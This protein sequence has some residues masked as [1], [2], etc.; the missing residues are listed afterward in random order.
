MDQ[1]VTPAAE[2]ART[3]PR[4]KAGSRESDHAAADRDHDTS[5]RTDA[6]RTPCQI[7]R[8]PG[9]TPARL[10]CKVL[11]TSRPHS[12]D[13][14]IEVRN[15]HK[16]HSGAD[17]PANAGSTTARARGHDRLQP[18][19]R[20]RKRPPPHPTLREPRNHPRRRRAS[21][22]PGPNPVGTGLHF[23]D[24]FIAF[25]VDPEAYR[26]N[27]TYIV[28][29]QGKPPDFVLE[30]ASRSTGGQDTTNKDNQSAKP[31]S[32]RTGDGWLHTT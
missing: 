28:S 15:D 5:R 14:Q 7:H 3:R 16:A 18:S 27:N 11:E 31:Q 13:H 6:G 4:K 25:G 12:N 19:K 8:S 20:P 29:E 24:L 1:M 10:R 21:H 9:F 32:F 23:P 17:I 30:I 26:R 22:Q 2:A